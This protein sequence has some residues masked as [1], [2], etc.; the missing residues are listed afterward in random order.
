MPSQT[1]NPQSKQ[2]ISQTAAV[3]RNAPRNRKYRK[4]KT[5]RFLVPVKGKCSCQNPANMVVLEK[6]ILSLKMYDWQT[7]NLFD[8]DTNALV[9]H[10]MKQQALQ[11]PTAT[12]KL[13]KGDFNVLWI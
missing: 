4:T 3:A 11:A 9:S 13:L 6:K 5:P 7:N 2:R 12:S 10:T 1:Q 8:M